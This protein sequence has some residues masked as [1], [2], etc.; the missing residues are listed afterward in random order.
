MI[1]ERLSISRDGTNHQESYRSLEHAKIFLYRTCDISLPSAPA[2][3][4]LVLV[5]DFKRGYIGQ[6]TQLSEG[7]CQ[8]N[9]R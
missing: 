4:F 3:Y 6:I 7:F 2:L 9:S 8:H 1:L 5:R